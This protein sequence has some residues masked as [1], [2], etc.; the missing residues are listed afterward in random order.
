M[1]FR[2][3]S[4]P[5]P[6]PVKAQ[7]AP[8]ILSQ[9]S[10]HQT[11]SITHHTKKRPSTGPQTTHGPQA[12]PWW[13]HWQHP[14]KVTR[15]KRKSKETN[16]QKLQQ[17]IE[18][19]GKAKSMI[20][21]RR[22]VSD[23]L[24]KGNSSTH[25]RQNYAQA[26]RANHQ[27]KARKPQ[28]AP[29]AHMQAPPERMQLPLDECMQTTTWKQGSCNNSALTGQH[30]RSDRCA[31]CEQDQHSDRSDRW[32]RPVRPVH[33]RAQKWLEATWKPSKCI[34]QAISS[35]NFSPLLAMHES[36]KKCKT[37]NLELLK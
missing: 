2:A 20:T 26:K 35:S 31:T 24:G 5:A 27:T 12:P 37:F 21:W 15:E 14:R 6:T 18:S 4:S 25:P 3:C 34:Q 30:H 32:P 11:L 16:R 10:V 17:A 28:T 19:Q 8:A 29:P 7:P 23:P 36:R 22:Q 13:V 1:T 9:E 33:T